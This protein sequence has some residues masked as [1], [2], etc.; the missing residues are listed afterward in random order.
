MWPFEKKYSLKDRGFFQN[1][2]DW[3]THLL[4]GVDDGFQKLQDS[5][6]ALA[7]FEQLGVSEVW[8]T[9]HIMEDM[10]N[11]TEDLRVRFNALKEAYKGTIELHLGSENMMD[12][13]LAERL[14]KGDLLPLGINEDRLLVEMSCS[15]PSTR[16]ESFFRE[17]RSAGFFPLLAHPERYYYMNE[18][19]Y[20]RLHDDGV[21]FQLN[22]CSLC[23]A[24][25]P[26]V[27]H[28]ARWMLKN[29]MY[30]IAGSDIHCLEYFQESVNEKIRSFRYEI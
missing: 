28:K 24:Y 13:L 16:M 14:S 26:E 27:E 10:P 5:L 19:D 15:N 7:F 9:P 29:D 30:E 6:D 22:V 18:R 4:P 2:T 21:L 1:F 23:G 11:T 8:C 25:G 17:I 20:H 12:G 3:H